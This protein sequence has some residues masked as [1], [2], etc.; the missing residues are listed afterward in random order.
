LTPTTI[1]RAGM[2]TPRVVSET[3]IFE[4]SAAIM[5]HLEKEGDLRSKA[6]EQGLIAA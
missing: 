4:K 1:P 3:V 5:G 2:Y 6:I